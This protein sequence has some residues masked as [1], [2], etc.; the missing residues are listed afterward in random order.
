MQKVEL[1]LDDET[2]ERAQRMA[3]KRHS[4]VEQLIS[5][6]LAEKA[7][8]LPAPESIIGSFTDDADLLDEIVEEAMR[9]R[10]IRQPRDI[11]V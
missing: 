8:S 7:A 6:A 9:W 4:S 11:Y 2:Y 3:A 5:E 1:E 10:E